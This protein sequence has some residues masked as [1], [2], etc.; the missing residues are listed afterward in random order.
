MNHE[1]ARLESEPCPRR[2]GSSA[3]PVPPPAGKEEEWRKIINFLDTV[4]LGGEGLSAGSIERV[5]RLAGITY[6]L[7]G[8][9]LPLLA[10]DEVEN[11]CMQQGTLTP[12]ERKVMNH[13]V[14]MSIRMLEGLPFPKKLRNVPAYAGMHH[15][16]LNGSGYPGAWGRPPFPCPRGCWPWPMFWRR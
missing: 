2:E 6:A 14:E 8:V 3:A 11:L 7:S 13:H 15:E 1:L 4:N 12:A 16:R 9:E 5:R 10:P